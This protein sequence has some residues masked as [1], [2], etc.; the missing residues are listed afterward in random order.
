M[1]WWRFGA[2]PAN[3][4][5]RDTILT[6]IVPIASLRGRNQPAI[7]IGRRLDGGDVVT[8][9]RAVVVVRLDFVHRVSNGR[10]TDRQASAIISE[11]LGHCYVRDSTLVNAVEAYCAPW[12]FIQIFTGAVGQIASRN[13]MLGFSWK[14]RWILFGAAAVDSY[15]NARWPALV[16]VIVIAALSWSSG[17]FQS[18]WT[19][20][21]DDLGNERVIA[22]GLG[23]ELA[24]LIQRGD[25]SLA[26]SERAD[27]LPPAV[28]RRDPGGLG[29]EDESDAQRVETG[30]VPEG[31]RGHPPSA[32]RLNRSAKGS[33]RE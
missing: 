29:G 11:A 19:R 16:G 4:L 24:G 27:R 21:L 28:R 13:P 20:R 33:R 5:Q 31:C 30:D 7:W 15:R 2:A 6:A 23:P 18:R 12:Q 14:I 1:M 25:R 22:E 26:T 8:P 10:L 17:H 9:S 32:P 3:D